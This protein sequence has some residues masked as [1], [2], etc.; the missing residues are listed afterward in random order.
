VEIHISTYIKFELKLSPYASPKNDTDSV[1]SKYDA[2]LADS[3]SDVGVDT[4]KYGVMKHEIAFDRNNISESE[5][6]KIA[7]GLTRTTFFD[8]AVTKYVYTKK[9]NN[10][11]EISISCDKSVTGNAEALQPLVELRTELQGLFPNNKIVFNL[12]VDKLDNVVMRIE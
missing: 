6:N 4:K 5:V 3:T 1:V 12:V 9:V 10:D 2:I 11:F 8:E 7:D